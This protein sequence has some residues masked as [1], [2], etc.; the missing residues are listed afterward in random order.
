[1]G[2]A[3]SDDERQDKSASRHI[4]FMSLV[5]SRRSTSVYSTDVLAQLSTGIVLN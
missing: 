4:Y 3:M 2:L 5:I 1:M